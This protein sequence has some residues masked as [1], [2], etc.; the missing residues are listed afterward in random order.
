[1]AKDAPDPINVQFEEPSLNFLPSELK[2][3]AKVDDL[4]VSQLWIE[5]LSK[6][7]LENVRIN[8][9]SPLKYAPVVRT[10]KRHG[11]VEYSY[12]KS[13][14]ELLITR[15]DPSESLKLSF[16]P[17]L[18]QLESFT[19]PQI[20]IG[21]QE[22]S[23]LMVQLGLYK[24]YPSMLATYI[25]SIVMVIFAASALGFTTYLTLRDNPSIF[26]NS[27][28]TVMR[29]AQQR[30][31]KYGCPLVV[32]ENSKELKDK[33]LSG[34][35]YHIPSIIETNGVDTVKEL[36]LKDNIAFIECEN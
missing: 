5:N 20:I 8:L 33:L 21:T 28:Y 14:M 32:L 24:K 19:E 16:F 1:V 29:Q 6:R 12:D 22:L 3:K 30:L 9:T 36:W 2:K 25:F 26:P 10:N 23:S 4:L 31:S 34:P 15:L 13:K 7:V 17:E 27:K 18:D 11:E 35:P